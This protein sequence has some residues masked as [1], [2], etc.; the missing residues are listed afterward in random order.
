MDEYCFQ[1]FCVISCPFLNLFKQ[2]S[3]WLKQKIFKRL[4]K[5]KSKLSHIMSNYL[6]IGATSYQLLFI[7]VYRLYI[8]IIKR[9][10]ARYYE[11]L[12]ENHENRKCAC[13]LTFTEHMSLPESPF[14]QWGQ[15]CSISSFMLQCFVDHCPLFFFF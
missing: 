2:V 13:L 4:A 11:H 6:P 12:Q 7:F 8:V 5:N 1:F 9:S 3:L 15:R 14:V 10:M